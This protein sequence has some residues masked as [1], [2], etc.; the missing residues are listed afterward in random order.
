MALGRLRLSQNPTSFLTIFP[1]NCTWHDSCREDQYGVP[2]FS[3]VTELTFCGRKHFLHFTHSL[4]PALIM[5][6]VL[7][8]A[9]A[10]L[11]QKIPVQNFSFASPT[12]PIN[13]GVSPNTITNWIGAGCVG[14]PVGDF[15]VQSLAANPSIFPSGLPDGSQFAY[16]NAGYIFQDSAT[17]LVAGTTYTLTAYLGRCP[18]NPGAAGSISLDSFSGGVPTAILT[19]TGSVTSPLSTFTQ[20]TTTFTADRRVRTWG[21]SSKTRGRVR[22][23]LMRLV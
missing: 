18:D 16:V 6:A 23:I 4:I 14:N 11:A 22:S 15:G 12:V 2:L 17:T 9:S 21:L 8:S 7:T 10:S 1:R 3:A 19:S 20:F 13:T 5:L